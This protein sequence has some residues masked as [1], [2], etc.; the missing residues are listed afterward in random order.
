MNRL[1]A[2]TPGRSFKNVGFC[3][4]RKGR[5]NSV[6]RSERCHVFKLIADRIP[7]FVF[8]PKYQPEL[9]GNSDNP[10]GEK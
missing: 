9:D 5:N 4:M 2:C 3:A 10:R 6:S 8:I 7:Q 1:Q